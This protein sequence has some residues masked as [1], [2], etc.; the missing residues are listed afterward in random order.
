MERTYD[1]NNYGEVKLCY[2]FDVDSDIEGWEV[3]VKGVY[4]GEYYGSKLG[5]DL[6]ELT[7]EDIDV[8]LDEMDYYYL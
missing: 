5:C 6:E 4:I 8:I 1:T 2:F 3:T 7:D